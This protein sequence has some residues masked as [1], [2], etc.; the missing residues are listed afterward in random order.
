MFAIP[1][2]EQV[3]VAAP[4]D[5]HRTAVLNTVVVFGPRTDLA[6]VPFD[7]IFLSNIYEYWYILAGRRSFYNKIRSDLY[8]KHVAELPWNDPIAPNRNQMA[9]I[10][11]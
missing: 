10:N 7:L 5:P 8:P 4:F 3:P 9:A 2:I 11:T 6:D 1:R